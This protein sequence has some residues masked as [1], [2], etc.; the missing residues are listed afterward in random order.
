MGI[1]EHARRNL[2]PAIAQCRRLSLVGIVSRN[3]QIVTE[4]AQK[5]H[6][7]SYTTLEEL[8]HHD[9]HVVLISLPVGLHAACALQCLNAGTHVWCEKSLTAT[10]SDWNLLVDRAEQLD[11]SLCEGFMFLHHR[12]FRRIIEILAAHTLGNIRSFTA[13]FGFPYPPSSNVRYAHTLGGGALLDVGC[14]TVRMAT[15]IGGNH[16]ERCA[17]ALTHE[18][19]FDVDT[20]GCALVKCSVSGVHGLLDWGFGRSYCNTLEIWGENASLVVD[21]VFSKPSTLETT[22]TIKNGTTIIH[23]E[24]IPADNHFTA[25]LEYFADTLIHRS[26]RRI[27]WTNLRVQGRLLFDIAEVGHPGIASIQ[28]TD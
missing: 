1:G 14:Y 18:P 17:S 8:L 20:G 5:Y 21:R 27:E 9:I 10:R 4:E 24:S 11:R 25:M 28:F 16:M 22:L 12:Q 2:L 19:A 15:A 6:C 26:L 13:R 23:T 7:A 3:A